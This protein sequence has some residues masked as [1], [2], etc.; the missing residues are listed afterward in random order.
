MYYYSDIIHVKCLHKS[1][2]VE[3]IMTY[4]LMGTLF[5]GIEACASISFLEI[6]TRPLNGIGLYSNNN[7]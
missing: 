5:P 6:L 7:Y 2:P 3:V 1:I 4:M